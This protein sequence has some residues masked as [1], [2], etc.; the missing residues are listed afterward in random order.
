M[1]FR[2]KDGRLAAGDTPEGE[3]SSLACLEGTKAGRSK[4]AAE[5]EG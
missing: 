4:L 1:A 2:H 5:D 3:N